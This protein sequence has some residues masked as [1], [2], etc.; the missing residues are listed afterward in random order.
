MSEATGNSTPRLR[1]ALGLP[2]LVPYGI[3]LIQPT[4]P[5]PLF[6]AAAEKAHG[7]VVT[8]VMNPIIC[9]I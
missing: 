6:G 1:R 4:A 2:A 5:M 3:V 9:V 8:Y 7:H